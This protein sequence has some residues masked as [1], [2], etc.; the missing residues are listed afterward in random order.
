MNA[1]D[2]ARA[3]NQ[4]DARDSRTHLPFWHCGTCNTIIAR[5]IVES[6]SVVEIKCKKCG[7]LNRVDRRE[8]A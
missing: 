3:I 4:P 5:M 1:A 7:T 8:A 2:R 6:G